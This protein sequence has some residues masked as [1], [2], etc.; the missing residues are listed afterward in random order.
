MAASTCPGSSVRLTPR[1]VIEPACTANRV[2]H[3]SVGAVKVQPA[4]LRHEIC[5]LRD[6]RQG[7][8]EPRPA[9]LS[10]VRG[11]QICSWT[12][13][14]VG[15]EGTESRR[16]LFHDPRIAARRHLVT[17]AS[18]LSLGPRLSVPQL[19]VRPA[20]P[21]TRAAGADAGFLRSR[22]N[23]KLASGSGQWRKRR[24]E[25]GVFPGIVAVICPSSEEGF[26]QVEL[27]ELGICIEPG[28]M[29][30]DA[31]LDPWRKSVSR[32]HLLAPPRNGLVKPVEREFC[33]KK[34]DVGG[35]FPPMFGLRQLGD[36]AAGCGTFECPRV[37]FAIFGG[38]RLLAQLIEVGEKEWVEL[39]PSAT[40][41]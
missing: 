20:G 1:D 31:H 21:K 19:L 27:V 5:R 30:V 16:P 14:E 35:M 36:G 33:D 24:P 25:V 40:F 11:I 10:P 37:F 9:R 34:R 18:S 39:C 38:P 13:D 7:W 15:G 32:S 26:E 23:V 28:Q 22:Y 8:R 29:P 3:P 12:A 41:C 6:P 4:A 17:G 2:T